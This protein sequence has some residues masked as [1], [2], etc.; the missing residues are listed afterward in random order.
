MVKKI[1]RA[2]TGISKRWHGD[3]VMGGHGD[4]ETRKRGNGDKVEG[5]EVFYSGFW[6]LDSGF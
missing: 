4:I 6:I 3:A 1:R 2:E 5:M